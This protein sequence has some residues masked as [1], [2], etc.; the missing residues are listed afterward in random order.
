MVPLN[1]HLIMAAI[2]TIIA[3]RAQYEENGTVIVQSNIRPDYNLWQ[4]Q[5][6]LLLRGL[7]PHHMLLQ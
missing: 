3:L 1:P 4:E 7:V 5:V 2:N 6:L